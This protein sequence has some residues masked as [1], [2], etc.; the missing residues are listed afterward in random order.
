[1]AKTLRDSTPTSAVARLLNR[2]AA[3]RALE[4]L[5]PASDM[6]RRD[7]IPEPSVCERDEVP[8]IKREFILTHD[9][10]ETFC[11]LLT[12]FRRTTRS[13][14]TASQLFRAMLRAARRSL[15]A[16]QYEAH[17]LGP[18]RL[19]GN[20]REAQVRREEFE[21]RIGA[22]FASGLRAAAPPHAI[23]HEP[24]QTRDRPG[25]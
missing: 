18:L 11:E 24:G 6:D 22:A 9:A 4:P 10:D 17:Q 15:P 19:P 8:R 13:R 2:E 3:S 16:L 14:L 25:G 1:M 21:E 7:R 12:L 20:G 5:P 23:A